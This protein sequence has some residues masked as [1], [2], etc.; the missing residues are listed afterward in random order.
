VPVIVGEADRALALERRLLDAGYLVQAVRPPTVA[1]GTSR[2]RLVPT[3]A[4]TVAQVDGVAAG[5]RAALEE[6]G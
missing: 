3:A 5:L 4:H 2:V 1:P 6:L